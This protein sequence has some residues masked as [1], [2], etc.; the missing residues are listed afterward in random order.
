[1]S[2]LLHAYSFL[3]EAR[4][5]VK[6]LLVDKIEKDSVWVAAE[7]SLKSKHS[8]NPPV[9]TVCLSLCQCSTFTEKV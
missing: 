2:K 5:I 3:L 6:C 1:M 4:C 7:E 8:V 9:L